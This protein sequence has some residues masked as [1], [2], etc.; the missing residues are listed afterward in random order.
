MKYLVTK[1]KEVKC[2][3]N[4]SGVTTNYREFFVEAVDL[5]DARILARCTL[6]KYKTVSIRR[7]KDVGQRTWRAK[8]SRL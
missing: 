5:H 2:P 3:R 4:R 8:S 7:V 1:N 6:Y